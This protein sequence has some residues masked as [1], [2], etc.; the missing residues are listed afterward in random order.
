[1]NIRRTWADNIWVRG[2]RLTHVQLGF[3]SSCLH[4]LSTRGMYVH[5]TA[6]ESPM[7]CQNPPIPYYWYEPG[8]RVTHRTSWYRTNHIILKVRV[9]RVHN[10]H[11]STC[12]VFYMVFCTSRLVPAARQAQPAL[13]AVERQNESLRFAKLI[14]VMNRGSLVG[15][16]ILN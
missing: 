9:L 15:I 10:L 5:S 16:C 13:R 12:Q 8:L 3:N 4:T 2:H 14:F 1:M 11:K 6:L 7:L